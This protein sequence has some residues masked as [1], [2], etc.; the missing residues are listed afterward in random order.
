MSCADTLEDI[1]PINVPQ[2]SKATRVFY[3]LRQVDFNG[4]QVVS[5]ILGVE[6]TNPCKSCRTTQVETTNKTVRTL[7]SIILN[8]GNMTI[9]DSVLVTGNVT[10]GKEATL[11]ITG[12]GSL[13]INGNTT[14]NNLCGITVN[15]R[16]Y[17]NGGTVSILDNTGKIH[18]EEDNGEDNDN[19]TGCY[20]NNNIGYIYVI[21]PTIFS[22]TNVT[23]PSHIIYLENIPI[24]LSSF[25]TVRIATGNLITYVT[26]S[27]HNSA[28]VQIEYSLDAANFK[29]LTILPSIHPQGGIY[30]YL[31]KLI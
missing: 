1:K 30:T 9:S 11:T 29:P 21:H 24:V 16:L 4:T 14:F 7:S 3:R 22:R 6:G 27:E 10:I 5:E 12:T 31:H 28:Y 23:R 2:I 8:N 13:I 26:T 18:E 25:T 17:F 15:G 20:I 19:K